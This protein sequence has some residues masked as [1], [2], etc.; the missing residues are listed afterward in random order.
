MGDRFAPPRR[1]PPSGSTGN[2]AAQSVRLDWGA[3]QAT[4][5]RLDV[6]VQ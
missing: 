6:P 5:V 4:A 2:V 3:I 1:G